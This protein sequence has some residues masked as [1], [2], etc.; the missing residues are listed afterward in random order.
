MTDLSA[1]SLEG[2][3]VPEPSMFLLSESAGFITG[4]TLVVDGGL[5]LTPFQVLAPS[6]ERAADPLGDWTHRS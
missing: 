1:F 4:E 2:R 6:D 3:Q 5:R